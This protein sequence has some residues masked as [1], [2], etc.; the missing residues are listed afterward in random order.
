MWPPAK[1][2]SLGN[3]K[4]LK[5]GQLVHTFRRRLL[6]QMGLLLPRSRTRNGPASP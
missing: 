3:E 2:H 6:G 1:I 4:S 5:G